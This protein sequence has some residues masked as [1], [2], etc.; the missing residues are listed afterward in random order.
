MLNNAN[1]VI[2][3]NEKRLERLYEELE[4]CK[5]LIQDKINEVVRLQQEIVFLQESNS[6][7][8]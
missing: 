4:I 2:T 1:D 3:H 7:A 5:M 8:N 6:I